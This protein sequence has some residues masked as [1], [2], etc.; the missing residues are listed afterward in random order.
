[1][2]I[3]FISDFHLN[4]YALLLKYLIKS[5]LIQSYRYIV[6][7]ELDHAVL[8]CQCTYRSKIIIFPKP[9][10]QCLKSSSL[11]FVALVTCKTSHNKR[12]K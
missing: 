11:F 7:S 4:T 9:S 6:S 1:M 5:L 12:M 3:H 2:S 8:F 10:Q